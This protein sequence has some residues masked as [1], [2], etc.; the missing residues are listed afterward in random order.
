MI[1][2]QTPIVERTLYLAKP[3]DISSI[4][5]VVKEIN[6]IIDLDILRFCQIESKFSYYRL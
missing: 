1:T 2:L 5:D 6:K 3:I 4:N